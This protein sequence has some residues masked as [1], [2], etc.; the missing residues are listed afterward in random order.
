M[1]M[2]LKRPRFIVTAVV[3]LVTSYFFWWIFLSGDVFSTHEHNSPKRAAL[4]Q[5]R[6]AIDLGASYSEV[7]AAYW[8]LR[9]LH[10][11]LGVEDPATWVVSTPLE[12]L[13]TNW[14]MFIEFR[15]GKVTAVRIRTAKGN[16]PKNGPADKGVGA[17]AA[18]MSRNRGR[19]CFSCLSEV[20]TPSLATMVS[21]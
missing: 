4:V 5:L 19:C 14:E 12:F 15:D 18:L 8:R 16:P 9:T 6:D 10:L 7:L 13:V 20:G 3:T 17:V 21:C 11:T 1:S 2:Q